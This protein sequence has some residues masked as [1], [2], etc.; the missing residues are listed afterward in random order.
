MIDRYILVHLTKVVEF[1]DQLIAEQMTF[2]LSASKGHL[3]VHIVCG[4]ERVE[5]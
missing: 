2:L 3:D 5:S 4:S 1:I